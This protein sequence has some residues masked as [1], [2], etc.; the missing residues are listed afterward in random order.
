MKRTSY[1][2]MLRDRLP[3]VVSFA[4]K[5]CKAKN[6][7]IEHVYENSIGIYSEKKNRNEAARTVLGIGRLNRNFD[8]HYS[9]TWDNLNED[10]IDIWEAVESWVHWFE[11]YWLVIYDSYKSQTDKCA[12][13]NEILLHIKTHNLSKFN[14]EDANK[15]SN[16]LL[17]CCK[18]YENLR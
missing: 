1:R 10:E 4:L 8:F 18:E 9:I 2:E 16:Y 15:F 5:W 12:N 7:W 6:A 14:E 3:I 17:K 13:D 11:K